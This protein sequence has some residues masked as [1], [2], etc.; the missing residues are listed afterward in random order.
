MLE[1]LLTSKDL[2]TIELL[3]IGCAKEELESTIRSYLIEDLA[4]NTETMIA[5]IKFNP[6]H[7]KVG[8]GKFQVNSGRVIINWSLPQFTENEYGNK[9]FVEKYSYNYD[10]SSTIREKDLA[11][12]IIKIIFNQYN[13]LYANTGQGDD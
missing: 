8:S 6:K 13:Y 4:Y 2:S 10:Y 11:E 12:F 1:E 3:F 9:I 7:E 5:L